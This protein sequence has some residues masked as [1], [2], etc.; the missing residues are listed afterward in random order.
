MFPCTHWLETNTGRVSQGAGGIFGAGQRC[1]EPIG[2]VVFDPTFVVCLHKSM[3]V[4][5]NDRDPEYDEWLNLDYH[6][7]I[8]AGGSVGYEEQEYR[9][10]KDA[11]DWWKTEEYPDGPDF[12]QY[13]AK[14]QEEG[15]FDCRK[16]HPERWGT[17]RRWEMGYRRQ[18]AGYNLYAAV[19]EKCAF[20][21]PTGKVEIWSTI[22]ESYIGDTVTESYV[23]ETPGTAA[24]VGE[25]TPYFA[26][27]CSPD[28]DAYAGDIPDIDKFPHWFEPKNSRVQA[29]EWYDAN[30]VDGA[31][32]NSDNYLNKPYH[33][34]AG[35]GNGQATDNGTTDNLEAYKQAV[36]E[37]PEA[38]FIC[39]SGA[40][41]PVYFHSEHRQLPW[42]RELWPS[43]RFEMNPNDAARLGIEQGDWI[44]VRTPWG[45]IREVADL[46][47]G[48]KEGTTNANHAW[49]Y[50]EMDHAAHGFELVGINCTMDKY[51]QCW[52]CGAS[53]LR[54][55]PMVV[56]KATEENS[57]F[58]NPV[59]CDPWGNEAITNANDPRLKEW[60]A[61]DPRLDDSKVELTYASADA[62]GLQTLSLIKE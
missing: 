23:L 12:P 1:V 52:I 35:V 32:Y 24:K 4:P 3:G 30:L 27:V 22:C 59:P 44:W 38:T 40:R 8:Q 48:I 61:N 5:F 7:F 49:W 9:V 57:P 15:W 41:Q 46:Y 56:Y 13:A 51:A 62:K 47:Y 54:G 50:P 17:Y 11:T 45:A 33:G 39:T 6:D 36:K 42:C 25:K 60:L 58:G 21:T 10:L 28:R 14:F 2:D 18:Q 55:N 31:S 20:G 19:D 26:Q 37:N 34:I 16:W 43:P 29:P 53:Q